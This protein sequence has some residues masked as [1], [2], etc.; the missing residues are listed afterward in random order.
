M[1]IKSFETVRRIT[2]GCG[3][4]VNL[5]R[6]SSV[7]V[8]QILRRSRVRISQRC[9]MHNRLTAAHCL[10]HGIKVGDVAR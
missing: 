9:Q 10:P 7:D 8:K 1:M 5:E 3:S 4:L 2:F 6:A